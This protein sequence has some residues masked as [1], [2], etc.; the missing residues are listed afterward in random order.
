MDSSRSS[1]KTT[2]QPWV[3][4]A[5]LRSTTVMSWASFERFINRAKKSP[6]G[7]PPTQTIFMCSLS[8]VE[9]A[10]RLLHVGPRQQ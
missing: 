6:A 8:S 9:G 10:L 3:I 5:G 7:P 4:P 2:P 1:Q